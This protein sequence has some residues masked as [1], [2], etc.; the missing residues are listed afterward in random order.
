MMFLNI[1]SICHIEELSEVSITNL[2]ARKLCQLLDRASFRRSWFPMPLCDPGQS[3][4]QI[5]F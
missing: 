4:F 3:H 2:F 1:L 5:R